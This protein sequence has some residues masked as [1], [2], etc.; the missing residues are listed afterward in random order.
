M[1]KTTDKEKPIKKL[2]NESKE[3]QDKEAK[4]MS[5]ALGMTE[6]QYK[7]LLDITSDEQ[8]TLAQFVEWLQ[9]AGGDELMPRQKQFLVACFKLKSHKARQ[10]ALTKLGISPSSLSTW[11]KTPLFAECLDAIETGFVWSAT[12]EIQ[13]SLAQS[14]EMTLLEYFPRYEE[15]PLN[16]QL[17][18][19]A[20]YENYKLRA[21]DMYQSTIRYKE[22]QLKE[23][24]IARNNQNNASADIDICTVS[25][26]DNPDLSRFDDFE[27]F[28]DNTQ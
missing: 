26:S 20:N 28:G 16:D 21:L 3:L 8:T 10:V 5:E 12:G 6:S 15:L 9:E 27:D 2:Q 25:T 23:E 18:V 13:D 1:K 11:K 17:R 7:Q 4:R 24:R 19:K 22:N 14:A